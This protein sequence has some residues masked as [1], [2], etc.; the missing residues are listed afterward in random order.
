MTTRHPT[1]RRALALLLGGTGLVGVAYAARSRL[2]HTALVEAVLGPAQRVAGPIPDAAMPALLALGEI[3]IPTPFA[4]E[5]A[6]Y[7]PETGT[8]GSV[9]KAAL[10]EY[11]QR[12]PGFHQDC[13]TAA[14][15][16][17][18]L[19]GG[20][21][22]PALTLAERRRLAGPILDTPPREPD[23][24]L[25]ARLSGR[26]S[27]AEQSAELWAVA[28]PMIH[29]FYAGTPGWASIGY[30]RRR[31]DCSNLEDYQNPPVPPRLG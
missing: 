3:L 20:R 25:L 12:T 29:G 26:R 2:R 7:P 27:K 10:E 17:D 13:A 19:A 16:L 6:A 9:M 4:R 5:G 23:A 1:R 31:G 14:H 15:L 24:G 18:R 11:A 30:P 8:P 28:H 21:K 22:Y